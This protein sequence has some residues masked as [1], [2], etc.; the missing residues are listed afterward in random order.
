MVPRSILIA[1]GLR[2]MALNESLSRGTHHSVSAT[3]LPS[4]SLSWSIAV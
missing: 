1:G 2:T 4:F 3:C